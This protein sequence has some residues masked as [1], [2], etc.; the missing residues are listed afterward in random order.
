[1]RRIFLLTV[2]TILLAACTSASNQAGQTSSTLSSL[3]SSSSPSSEMEVSTIEVGSPLPHAIISSPL[4]I[5]GK[6]RGSWFFEAV[7]PAHLIDDQGNAIASGPVHAQSEW[8]TDDFV[9]FSLDL[10][11]TTNAKA[12]FL[13]LEKDNPSDLPQNAQSIRIP[14]LFK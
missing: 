9:P 10:P 3:A 12:G 4:H 6:A 2:P 13:V 5:E 8:M 1:M 7:F 11:F 14:V